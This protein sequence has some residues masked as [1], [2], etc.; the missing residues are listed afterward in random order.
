M[1]QIFNKTRTLWS[2]RS[3]ML[4]NLIEM[5][6]YKVVYGCCR[7]LN[8]GQDATVSCLK[9]V[10]VKYYAPGGKRVRKSYLLYIRQKN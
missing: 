1:G 3:L 7:P 9:D 4:I 8:S 2:C 6:V 10:F 5:V